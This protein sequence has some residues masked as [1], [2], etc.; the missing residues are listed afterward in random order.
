MFAHHNPPT[1]PWERDER[2]FCLIERYGTFHPSPGVMHLLQKHVIKVTTPVCT[3]ACLR[4][5]HLVDPVGHIMQ[6]LLVALFLGV[7]GAHGIQLCD[8]WIWLPT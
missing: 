3:T 1:E 8:R 4:G 5:L 6:E 7:H 2:S